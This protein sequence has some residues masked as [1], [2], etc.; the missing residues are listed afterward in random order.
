M[1]KWVMCIVALILGMLMA[2]MFKDV[3]GCKT[4]EGQ[5]KK[6]KWDVFKEDLKIAVP[7]G[8]WDN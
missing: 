6:S 1:D 2:N 3:C 8:P 7:V 5:G 4:V